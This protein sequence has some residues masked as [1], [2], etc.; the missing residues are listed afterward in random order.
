MIV[1]EALAQINA[2][3]DVWS[4]F[5][6]Q[7]GVI[8]AAV[9]AAVAWAIYITAITLRDRVSTDAVSAKADAQTQD[10]VNTLA[11]DLRGELKEKDVM[12]GRMREEFAR[13]QGQSKAAIEGL[14]AQLLEQKNASERLRL[15]STALQNVANDWK[16]MYNDA[17]TRL[18]EHGEQIA[19]MRRD[20]DRL[21]VEA[22]TASTLNKKLLND[23]NSMKSKNQEFESEVERLRIKNE[24]LRGEKKT[25]QV[26]IP[27]QV[28]DAVAKAAQVWHEEKAE[29]E[30]K[31]DAQNRELKRLSSQELEKVDVDANTDMGDVGGG[32]SADGAADADDGTDGDRTGGDAAD[33]NGSGDGRGDRPGSGDGDADQPGDGSPQLGLLADNRGGG[34]PD[35][36]RQQVHDTP[37]EQTAAVDDTSGGDGRAGATDGL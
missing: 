21:T 26:S 25:L 37:R 27:S 2:A 33:G 14:K 4:A 11:I 28:S 19:E 9:M 24:R 36:D 20:I 17:A 5:A 22:E 6:D 16:G 23:L 34:N 3:D 32:A 31:L 30:R 7:F 10:V 8:E 12:L 15:E 18:A 29:L 1:L 13:H 35:T